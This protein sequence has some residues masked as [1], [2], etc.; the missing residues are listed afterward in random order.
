ME[1]KNEG[2]IIRLIDVVLILLFGFITISKIQETSKVLL[3]VSSESR[4]STPDTENLIPVTIQPFGQNRYSYYLESENIN[5]TSIQS[6]YG[7]LKKKKSFFKRD[8][9]LKIYSEANAPIKYTME[10]ADLCEQ[11][12][13]KK[14]LIVKLQTKQSG[15]NVT[16]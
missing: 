6:L 4:L 13:L 1:G 2:I 5:F 11:L 3:P 7:Y 16:Y 14:S 10:I 8:I 15:L 9:R 12:K